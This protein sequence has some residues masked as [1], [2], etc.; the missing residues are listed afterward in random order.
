[1]IKPI[2]FTT[3]SEFQVELTDDALGSLGPGVL[4]LKP[5]SWPHITFSP[6]SHP[7]L[8]A[9][10][11]KRTILRAETADGLCFTLINCKA[12][13]FSVSVDYV[14]AGS[15][16]GPFKAFEVRYRDITDWY[17]PWR[18][19]KEDADHQTYRWDSTPT[20]IDATVTTT[21][22]TFRITTRYDSSVETNGEDHIIHEHIL[23]CFTAVGGNFLIEDIETK[24]TELSRLL[25]ILLAFPISIVSIHA[26]G[27][28]DF[29]YSVIFPEPKHID[30]RP[31][32]T[33]FP[34]RCFV[35]EPM[36]RGQWDTV[37]NGYFN[38]VSGI[39]C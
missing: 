18:A 26:V 37:L 6:F 3:S 25:S 28:N 24:A 12:H 39:S 16:D 2:D 27:Q 23:F 29:R 38:W 32:G 35:Q 7:M 36:L 8:I 9:Q 1:M 22:E 11:T 5:G 14:I 21:Q 17:S 34:H 13:L 10:G 31:P 15:V 30:K 19:L 33:V 20:H 4:R